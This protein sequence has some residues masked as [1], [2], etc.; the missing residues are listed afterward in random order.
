MSI[1]STLIIRHL[2]QLVF[3]GYY[4][5]KNKQLEIGPYQGDIIACSPI[6]KGKGVCG[7]CYELEKEIIVPNVVKFPGYI[8]C[9]TITKSEIAIPVFHENKLIA[10]LDLDGKN[11]NQFNSNDAIQLSKL[12][13][14]I[15]E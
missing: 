1:S 12:M 8:A 5:I 2:P 14:K 7:K 11:L 9:D 13:S 6:Q 3:A 15:F 10:I 4:L